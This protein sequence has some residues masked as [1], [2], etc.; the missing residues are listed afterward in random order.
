MN[1]LMEQLPAWLR[2]PT[3]SK[4]VAA[5]VAVLIVMVLVRLTQRTAA[6]YAAE[7]VLL[8]GQAHNLMQDPDWQTTA[9]LIDRWLVNEVGIA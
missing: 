2:D 7:C 1:A 5:C 4:I 6:R 8:P 3:M 9:R